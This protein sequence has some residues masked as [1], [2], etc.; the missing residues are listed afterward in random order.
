MA[1]ARTAVVAP[2]ALRARKPALIFQDERSWRRSASGAL[3]LRM[4][5]R[6]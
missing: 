3:F 2:V 4:M 1:F 6:S 5:S